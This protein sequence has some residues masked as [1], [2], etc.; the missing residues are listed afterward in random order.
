MKP[1][2]VR[3][4]R[5]SLWRLGLG[6]ALLACGDGTSE[7]DPSAAVPVWRVDPE[8]L[9]IIGRVEGPEEELLSN[10]TGAVLLPGG[11]VAVADAGSSTVRLFDAEG[12][13][14]S[15]FG[16]PGEGPGE[17]GYIFGL[18]VAGPDRLR[19]YDA[20]AQRLS[21]F[22]LGGELLSSVTFRA[23]TGY[24]EIYLGSFSDGGHAVAWIEQVGR[25][26]E[27]VTPDRM[28]IGRFE[29]DGGQGARLAGAEGMLRLGRGPLPF[30]PP[31]LAARVAAPLFVADGRRP[32]LRAIS[33]DGRVLRTISLPAAPRSPRDARDALASGL[34]PELRTTLAELSVPEADSVPY[35]SDLLS[36]G[37]GRLWVKLYDPATDSH[38]RG[39]ARTGGTWLAFAT[40]GTPLARLHLPDDLRLLGIDD[41]RL[42]GLARDDLDVERIRLHAVTRLAG[43][44]RAAPEEAPGGE[45]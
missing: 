12:E 18:E 28:A 8:P 31:F 2:H 22:S 15:A 30:S 37:A 11:G 1:L 42:V 5:G 14:R 39:R 21:T 35:L 23:T 6:L 26:P 24:P 41:T 36:D 9:A 13:F 27:R 43:V 16:G 20:D 19:V 7:P 32:E 3:A 38:W 34:T 25:D 17:F 44:D 45:R 33:P 10:V 40:D 29:V 4:V